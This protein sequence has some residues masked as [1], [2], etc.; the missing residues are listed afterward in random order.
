MLC[1]YHRAVHMTTTASTKGDSIDLQ[2][3][4]WSHF[5]F[6]LRISLTLRPLLLERRD[7]RERR[8]DGEVTGARRLR[9]RERERRERRELRRRR[10][11]EA[12]VGALLIG[13]DV[14]MVAPSVLLL[15]RVGESL[16]EELVVGSE[17]EVDEEDELVELVR[18]PS[19]MSSTGAWVDMPIAVA[20][21]H[22]DRARRRETRRRSM[23][24]VVVVVGAE[25]EKGLDGCCW[26]LALKMLLSW[27]APA[28]IPASHRGSW[29]GAG[30]AWYASLLFFVGEWGVGTFQA[31][32]ANGHIPSQGHGESP[33]RAKGACCVL[34]G[35]IGLH[36]SMAHWFA[37]K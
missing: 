2:K 32:P 6:P 23:L 27:A 29:N 15:A 11:R 36:E 1:S 21:R 37:G 34:C 7:R 30:G 33:E 9:E 8:R 17:V 16:T 14:P 26:K 20:M 12:S 10:R 13:A 28:L 31:S 25:R 5:T 4:V 35:G 3:A 19:R 22:T 18:L 24:V